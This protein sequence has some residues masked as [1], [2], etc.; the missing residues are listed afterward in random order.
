VSG[1]W[2]HI[3]ECPMFTLKEV[4]L[5]AGVTVRRDLE[6]TCVAITCIEGHG[7]LSTEG[8]SIPIREMQTVLVPA[9]AEAWSA[10]SDSPRMDLL[11]AAPV[12]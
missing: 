2:R 9:A 1:A 3:I 11:L 8:G 10:R 12:L 7:V 5:V 6:G 4:R